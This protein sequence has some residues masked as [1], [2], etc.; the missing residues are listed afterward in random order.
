VQNR[1]FEV[2]Q[3]SN[4]VILG[5]SAV[6]EGGFHMALPQLVIKIPQLTNMFIFVPQLSNLFIFFS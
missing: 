6:L 4:P 2:P 1:I 3:L 5:L